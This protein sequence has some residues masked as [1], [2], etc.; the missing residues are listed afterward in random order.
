MTA[1]PRSRDEGTVLAVTALAILTLVGIAAFAVDLGMYYTAR[2]EAQRAADAAA[3]AGAGHL[4]VDRDGGRVRAEAQ[5]YAARNLVH[6]TAALLEDGD[7]TVDLDAFEVHV[8]LHR[9]EAR[10][11]PIPTVFARVLGIDHMDLVARAA[12]RADPATAANCL[13]PIALPDRW[14]NEGTFQWDPDEGDYYQKPAPDGSGTGYVL[15]RDLGTTILLKGADGSASSF[16]PGWWYL[17][18]PGSGPGAAHL[19]EYVTSCPNP[20]VIRRKGDWVTD[21]GGVQQSIVRAFQKVIDR[22]P[23]AYWS[24]ECDCVRN[25]NSSQSPRVRGIPLFDPTT[26]VKT[27]N[28]GNFQIVDF[29]GVFIEAI[30][31]DPLG[32]Q[33]IRGRLMG[34]SGFDPV[35]DP[36]AASLVRVAR[37]IE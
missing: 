33:V 29:A 16:E 13:V 20:D 14:H 31:S 37:L 18:Q 21:K 32:Q 36:G 12:A 17:W 11:N 27:S 7:V 30:E 19:D 23:G 4:I 8:T 6:G 1:S 25:S 10:G 35:G 24:E 5:S 9:T 28:A 3:L 34:V 2:A 22:D 15:P 26:Y